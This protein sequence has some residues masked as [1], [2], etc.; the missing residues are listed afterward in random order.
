MCAKL[1]CA[2][3]RE[4]TACNYVE[5]AHIRSVQIFVRWDHWPRSRSHSR[6]SQF[7]FVNYKNNALYNLLVASHSHLGQFASLPLIATGVAP[8]TYKTP[9][10]IHPQN[11]AVRPSVCVNDVSVQCDYRPALDE[12]IFYLL[13]IWDVTYVVCVQFFPISTFFENYFTVSIRRVLAMATCQTSPLI[14]RQ[15]NYKNRRKVN[16]PS[17]KNVCHRTGILVDFSK[18]VQINF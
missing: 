14:S 10:K 5:V 2:C 11:S 18:Q 8:H 6:I 9:R 12:F 7:L 4:R 15:Q 1:L 17:F 16:V 13:R 3:V